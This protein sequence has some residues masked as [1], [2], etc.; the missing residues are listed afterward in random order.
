MVDL[1]RNLLRRTPPAIARGN[2][3]KVKYECSLLYQ[4]VAA[5]TS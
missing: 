4:Y 5:L 2:E 1:F 3:M